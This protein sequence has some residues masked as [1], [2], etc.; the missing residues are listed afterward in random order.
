MTVTIVDHGANQVLRESRSGQAEIDAGVLGSKAGRSEGGDVTVADVARWA[1]LGLGQPQRSWL[2][3]WIDENRSMIE[4]RLEIEFRRVYTGRG[5]RD[6]ALRRLGVWLQGELQQNIANF[7]ANNFAPN[8]SLTIERKG[9]STPLIDK[10][11]FRS[12]ISHRIRK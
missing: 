6:Q 3:G 7:P 12:S 1:E 8:A 2:R 11:Q 4:E 9:S 5:T 10:G